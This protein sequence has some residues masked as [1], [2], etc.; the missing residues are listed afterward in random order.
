MSW[1]SPLNPFIPANLWKIT[2]DS[3]FSRKQTSR[4]RVLEKLASWS[5]M[6]KAAFRMSQGSEIFETRY[7]L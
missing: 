2:G 5:Q 7:K 4:P 6:S 1:E 3:V